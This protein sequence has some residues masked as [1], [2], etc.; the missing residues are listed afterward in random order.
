MIFFGL[1]TMSSG[2]KNPEVNKLLM[3]LFATM[4]AETFLGVIKCAVIGLATMVVQSSSATLGI[5]IALAET[6]IIEFPT[7]AGLILG[8]NIGTTITALL[9]SLGTTVNARRA[10]YAH[11]IFNVVGTIWLLPVFFW[12]ISFIEF[13]LST[14][15]G[16][17]SL[18]PGIVTKIALMIRASTSSIQLFFS[19]S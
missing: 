12:Y 19:L 14:F 2:F 13:I 15:S 17:F 6:G 11:I 1:Q 16:V 18:N 3:N 8:L 5:T 9:A 4:S 10:A 7:A